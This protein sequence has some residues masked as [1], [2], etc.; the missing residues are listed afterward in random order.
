MAKVSGS[1]IEYYDERIDALMVEY[2]RYISRV[3]FI[4]MAD[5]FNHIVN[6]PCHR[7][8][9]SHH[10]AVVVIAEMFKGATNLNM[11][12]SKREMFKEIFDR[13]SHLKSTNPHRTLS[14]LV[15]EVIFQ[16]AP[17]FYLSA[18]SARIMVYKA[19]KSW[20]AK[21]LQKLRRS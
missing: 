2:D 19:K 1:I 20:Y 14:S 11:R 16:P 17:K 15:R 10:R 4:C 13:V 9:V 8:W 21:K 6:Q 7:F 18:S 12:P 3:R 5:V